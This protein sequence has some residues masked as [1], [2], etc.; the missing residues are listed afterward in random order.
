M[1]TIGMENQC[2]Q[3][4]DDQLLT[5]MDGECW[6]TRKHCY[7][8]DGKLYQLL[9]C[10]PADLCAVVLAVVIVYLSILAHKG[11]FF[12]VQLTAYVLDITRP[13]YQ[14]EKHHSSIR[15]PIF[16]METQGIP[17]NLI[18]LLNLTAYVIFSIYFSP[19]KCISL[20]FFI[21]LVAMVYSMVMQAI[22]YQSGPCCS[23]LLLCA[24]SGSCT[25]N[26]VHILLQLLIFVTFTLAEHC[27]SY[28]S[29]L[30]IALSLLTRDP[31]LVALWSVITRMM[32]ATA[33]AFRVAFRKY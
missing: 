24:V 9:V 17:N 8:L 13:E 5:D 31:L 16:W 10:I 2:F 32:F 3:K 12:P 14:L 1:F 4:A 30:G 26:Q 23:Y 33:C 15:W 20:G 25:L 11:L 22:I 29:L 28:I 21:M 7:Y 18:K 19:I 27:W 6:V